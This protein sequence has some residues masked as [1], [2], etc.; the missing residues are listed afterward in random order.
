MSRCRWSIASRPSSS[1]SARAASRRS[2][3]ARR[4]AVRRRA[5]HRAAPNDL[6]RVPRRRRGDRRLHDPQGPVQVRLLRRHAAAAVR[7]RHRPAGDARPRAGAG[8]PGPRRRLRGGA[9]PVVDPDAAD[10]LAKADQRAR[11]A[12]M[13]GARRSSTAA[14]SAIRRR[15]APSRYTI[16]LFRPAR[17]RRPAAARCV[18]RHAESVQ[19]Q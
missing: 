12:A 8:L 9:A 11:I 3:P 7:P 14:A 13:A 2:R 16:D 15:R 5:R 10:A 18:I 4:I 19:K 6:V 17:S 1:A